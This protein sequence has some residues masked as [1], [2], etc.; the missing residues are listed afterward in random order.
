MIQ[1]LWNGT[2]RVFSA[3]RMDLFYL[4]RYFSVKELP[5]CAP[6]GAPTRQAR[7][8]VQPKK[9]D[10]SEK[11]QPI[12]RFGIVAAVSAC[13][14]RVIGI[15]GS[16]P[17]SLPEDRTIF[18]S[19]T[20]GGV[21]I[22]GRRTFE[23][24]SNLVHVNHAKHC[25]VVSKSVE[26]LDDYQGHQSSDSVDLRLAR[27]FSE[28]LHLARELDDRIEKD[29]DSNSLTCWVGG[30]EKVYEE[31]LRHSSAAEL[32]LSWVQVAIPL[33][34][35]RESTK[36]AQFPAKYR[37]DNRFKPVSEKVY[38]KSG[39]K[40]CFVYSVYKPVQKRTS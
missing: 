3:A 27:S 25:I 16:I 1:H 23:E 10:R 21:L 5:W 24:H 39:T 31:A 7:S 13:N 18:K 32:H 34:S 17:W 20:K 6:S 2:G 33:P 38:P 8:T 9:I 4:V 36:V 37:W 35:G 15:D 22:I 14:S 12:E 28:A 30:G 19:L 29:I 40:P 26:K 11:Y